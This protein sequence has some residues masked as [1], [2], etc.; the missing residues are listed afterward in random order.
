MKR[1]SFESMNCSLARTLELVG[2]WW[3][4]LIIREAMWGT[5]RF[6]DFHGR[7]GIARNV[8]ATRLARLEECGLLQRRPTAENARIHDYLLTEKGWDLF[9]AI[10]A[11]MQWGDRWLHAKQGP[12]I[13]FF[14]SV[15]GKPIQT[16]AVRD[17]TGEVLRPMEIDI[18][19]GPGAR[20][21]TVHRAL[22]AR[23]ARGAR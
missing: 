4:L 17:E 10:V 21:A 7:L 14:D 8:L 23:D 13:Q 22:A 3:T 19:P 20:R 9:T 12:P 16:L 6:D 5:K 11:L 1:S 18:R 2:E 15:G